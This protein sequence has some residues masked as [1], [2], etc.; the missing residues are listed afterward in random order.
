[1]P[2]VLVPKLVQIARHLDED[3]KVRLDADKPPDA[4]ASSTAETLSKIEPP[5]KLKEAQRMT[6]HEKLLAE[7]AAKR[8]EIAF[9]NFRI[10]WSIF[11][12][13][14]PFPEE[15]AEAVLAQQ[16]FW[17]NIS[18]LGPLIHFLSFQPAPQETQP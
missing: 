14:R 9:E 1:V 2:E 15:D 5:P 4:S 7:L 18:S 16:L 13:K 8:R 11:S 3:G 12:P 6:H 17:Q 10:S